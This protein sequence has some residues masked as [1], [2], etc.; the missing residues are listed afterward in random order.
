MFPFWILLQLRMTEVV[1]TTGA[2]S[3]EK[4]QIIITSQQTQEFFFTGWMPFVLPNQQCQSTEGN[5]EIFVCKI[6]IRVNCTNTEHINDDA[7]LKY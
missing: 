5:F 3:H 7:F 6:S 1:V 4:L 2:I